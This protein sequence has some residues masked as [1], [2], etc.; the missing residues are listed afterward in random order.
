MCDNQSPRRVQTLVIGGGLGGLSSAFLTRA[1]HLHEACDH[2]KGGCSEEFRDVLVL[3]SSSR[4]GGVIQ[5]VQV[6]AVDSGSSKSSFLYDIGPNSLLAKPFTMRLLAEMNRFAQRGFV[7]DENISVS[8]ADGHTSARD[9]GGA[10]GLHQEEFIKPLSAASVAATRYV[11]RGGVMLPISLNPFRLS[12]IIG[13]RGLFRALMEPFINEPQE[14]QRAENGHDADDADDEET[15]AEFFDR[16]LGSAVRQTLVDAF[17]GGIY[18]GDVTC[19]SMKATFPPIYKGVKRCGSIFG[20]L[21]RWLLYPAIPP[22][23]A[24]NA[25]TVG[26]DQR[27]PSQQQKQ[28][29]VARVKTFSFVGGMEDLVRGLQTCIDKKRIL[30]NHTVTHISRMEVDTSAAKDSDTMCLNDRP[31]TSARF[32]VKA[33]NS[34]NNEHVT[35][36]VEKLI[37]ATPAAEAASLLSSASHDQP[38]TR[39]VNDET[40]A[41]LNQI[42]YSSISVIGLGPEYQDKFNGSM[43][44]RPRC[45]SNGPYIPKAFG[46]LSPRQEGGTRILG[47]IFNSILFPQNRAPKGR[48]ALTVFIGGARDPRAIAL[49]DAE[50]HRVIARDLNRVLGLKDIGSL[51]IIKRWSSGIPAYVKG[52]C[53]RVKRI[54]AAV[55]EVPGLHLVG[56]YLSGVAVADTIKSA[57]EAARPEE[58]AAEAQSSLDKEESEM[59]EAERKLFIIEGLAALLSVGS[60]CLGFAMLKRI[61]N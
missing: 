25:D 46:F 52:H 14:R 1:H 10:A 12:K 31:N 38:Q 55:A 28:G 18:A 23:S 58:A 9:P 61:K 15:V 3:E 34:I 39:I 41:A 6:D 29:V 21:L 57:Y 60:L 50:L 11:V 44:S 13:W 56:N 30:T 45:R 40:V 4:V 8:G 49:S 53:A 51:L 32:F 26:T 2:K 33:W 27:Q 19:L 43:L 36:L 59:A 48:A 5:S 35:F 7:T 54:K 47:A 42:P 22:T 20:L 16:R 24:S 17:V 37:V